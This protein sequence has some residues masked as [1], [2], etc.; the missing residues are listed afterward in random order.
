M[1][2]DHARPIAPPGLFVANGLTS[3]RVVFGGA[4]WNGV[5]RAVPLLVAVATTPHLVSVLGV[6]RWGVF[7]LALSLVGIFGIFDF[8]IGR[9]ITRLVAERLGRGDAAGAAA[10][11]RT[12]LTLLTALGI[13]GGGALGMVSAPLIH[14]VLVM[15]PALQPQACRALYVLCLAVPLAVINGGLWGILAAQQQFRASNLVTV[16]VQAGYYL[17]PLLVLLACD[18]LAAVIATLV[19]AR[20]AMTVAYARLCLRTL[21]ELRQA[22][23][24]RA[25]LRPILQQGGWMTLANLMQPLLLYLDR[26][27]VAAMLSVAA[28]AYYATPY[29][30]VTRAWLIPVA[31]MNAVY[32][33]LA[34]SF[35]AEP[36]AATRLYH[37]ANL[38]ILILLLPVCLAIVLGG[39]A[40]LRLWLGEEFSQRAA[41][42]LRW[43]GVGMVFNCLGFV[44][45]G[46]LDAIGRADV[47]AKWAG[48]QALI[49]LPL[50]FL[51]IEV[52]GIEGAAIG[53]TLRA[54]FDCTGRLCIAAW[55]YPLVRSRLNAFLGTLAL[56]GGLLLALRLMV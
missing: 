10:L 2:A 12:G 18:D 45:A 36:A 25:W 20:L 30:L 7:T 9:A 35:R 43:L 21:P 42:V 23:F 8:G 3:V 4:L 6:D 49:Y 44:P 38:S 55:L 53:W 28:T 34:A 16:P 13:C 26:F 11:G 31:I 52:F 33:A 56:A 51:C 5:G 54:A 29:D 46:L 32:P 50:L 24:D 19:L 39:E 27:V 22:R 17:G 1:N 40:G 14:D 47:N 48:A 41:P 37:R 15:P